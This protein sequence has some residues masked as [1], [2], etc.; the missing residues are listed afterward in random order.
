M[1]TDVCQTETVVFDNGDPGASLAGRLFR[2]PGIAVIVTGSQSCTRS[3]FNTAMKMGRTE[4]FFHCAFTREDYITGSHEQRLQDCLSQVLQGASLRGVVFYASCLDVLTQTDFYRIIELADNPSNIP[5][6]VLWRGPLVKRYRSPGAALN[7]ILEKLSERKPEIGLAT[8]QRMLPP[9]YPDFNSICA[10]LQNWETF[11]FLITTGGCSGCLSKG[12]TEERAYHL[13]KSRLNDVQ[14]AQGC[15]DILKTAIKELFETSGQ[16]LACLIGSTALSFTGQGS[17]VLSRSLSGAGVPNLYFPTDGFA[18]GPVG[19]SDAYLQLGKML[20]KPSSACPRMINI[21]GYDPMVFGSTEQ[22][23]PGIRALR[24]CGYDARIWG[25]GS[26]EQAAAAGGAALNWVVTAAGIDLAEYMK[27]QFNLP[28]ICGMPIGRRAQRLW[29][30]DVSAVLG[31]RKRVSA[32]DAVQPCDRQPNIMV[33]G[34]PVLSVGIQQFLKTEMGF[35]SV[36][37]AAYCPDRKLRQFYQRLAIDERCL[38]FSDAATF[39]IAV[40]DSDMLIADPIYSD[41][42]QDKQILPMPYPQIGG[43]NHVESAALFGE[44]A[45]SFIRKGLSRMR[46]FQGVNST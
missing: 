20:L 15:D 43:L 25:C 19:L 13:Y 26:L 6:E 41:Y 12:E 9:L 38:Y 17:D 23:Q 34:E 28:Y 36:S 24:R 39:Q 44:P 7:L 27:I 45:G 18:S 32:P 30:N 21:L 11:N 29:L 33:I 8:A 40:Q 10:G 5:I 35:S 37:T 31:D 42:I 2:C 4:Q 14:I 1:L 3:I 16:K 22:L 46:C